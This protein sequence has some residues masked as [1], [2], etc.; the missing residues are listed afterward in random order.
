MF[1]VSKCSQVEWTPHLYGQATLQHTV[2]GDLTH[3][4]GAEFEHLGSNGILLH[5][6]LL[7]TQGDKV[8]VTQLI[9]AILH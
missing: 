5:Q 1:L 3:V 8:N 4:A 2:P 9:S 7:E 6:G